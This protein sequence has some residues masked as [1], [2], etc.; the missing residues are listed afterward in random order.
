M[1]ILLNLFGS[2]AH[3]NEQARVLSNNVANLNTPGFKASKL[4]ELATNNRRSINLALTSPLHIKQSCTRGGFSVERLNGAEKPNGNNVDMLQQNTLLS[5][6]QIK[7][8]A[9]NVLFRALFDF[10]SSAQGSK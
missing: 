5:L 3:C 10:A 2:L 1:N 8:E 9:S 7:H 6:N 4:A